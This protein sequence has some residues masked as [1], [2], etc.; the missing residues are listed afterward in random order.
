[1]RRI[2]TFFYGIGQGFAGLARNRMFSLAS[3]ATMAAC[4][5]LFGIFYIGLSN[6]NHMVREAENNVGLT[7]FFDDGISYEEIDS[8]GEKLRK[9]AEVS[10]ITFTSG[11][12]AWEKYKA[13]NLSPEMIATFGDDNPLK[14][15]SS[16]TVYL[17]KSWLHM[18]RGLKEYERSTTRPIFPK[19]LQA[20]TLYSPPFR[21]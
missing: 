3:I 13:E 20:L 10:K 7:V 6:F 19:D 15:S 14:D 4:L 21:S 16:F 12:E 1:M 17:K 5:F 11:D 8:I 2:S 18:L 9:R